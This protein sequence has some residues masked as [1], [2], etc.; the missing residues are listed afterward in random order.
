MKEEKRNSN[1]E[2]L[3][4]ISMILIIAYH[5]RNVSFVASPATFLNG[6]GGRQKVYLIFTLLL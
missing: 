4:I 1:I 5:A 3:R 6:G 2:L